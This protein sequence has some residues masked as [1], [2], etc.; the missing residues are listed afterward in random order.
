MGLG[1]A[2]GAIV[3]SGCRRR[4]WLASDRIDYLPMTAGTIGAMLAPLNVP[5]WAG[6]LVMGETG[7]VGRAIVIGL[8]ALAIPLAGM[9]TGYALGV[10]LRNHV[11]PNPQRRFPLSFGIGHLLALVLAFALTFWFASAI[12]RSG[13]FGL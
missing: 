9:V 12:A 7:E 4:S 2:L 1:F 13:S 5:A 11:L 6:V 3:R 8:G 10:S